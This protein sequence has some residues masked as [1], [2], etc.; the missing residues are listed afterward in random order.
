MKHTCP[1]CGWPELEE[2]PRDEQNC[3]SYEICPCCGFEF[4][5]DDDAHGLTYEQARA[6]WIGGGMKWWST[7][8]PSPI[9]W[10]P[11]SQLARAGLGGPV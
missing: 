7:A 4:G 6:R 11:M 10:N 3:A 5:F 8:R 9:G 2:L 1:V